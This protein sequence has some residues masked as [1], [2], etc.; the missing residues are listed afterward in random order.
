LNSD[1]ITV[2]EVAD[3]AIQAYNGGPL[4]NHDDSTLAYWPEKYNDH[5]VYALPI[6]VPAP[7]I[8][9]ENT[10]QGE[11]KISWGPHVESFS[12]PRLQGAFHHYELYKSA[13]PLGHWQQLVTVSKGDPL[14]FKNGVYQFIDKNT[15]VGDNWYYSVLSV[16]DHANTSGRTNLT[17]NQSAIGATLT[18]EQVYIA[19]NP[20]IV[21]SGYTSAGDVD[22]QL[23]FYNLPKIC[24]IRIYS[25]SGQLIQT[26]EHD[27][28]NIQHP[29]VQITRNNQLIASGVYFYSVDTPEGSRCHGKFVII[30]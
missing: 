19:P 30:N 14:Y 13:H 8:V 29:Y 7:A 20:F 22:S 18:L 6:P 15:R 2:R 21:K 10:A 1:V 5:G 27:V 16:D 12:A 23:R 17:L 11:N 9:V 4:I 24:T 28:N 3:R 25:F 26:I